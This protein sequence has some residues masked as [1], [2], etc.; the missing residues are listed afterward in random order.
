L[1]AAFISAPNINPNAC[2]E[3]VSFAEVNNII[4]VRCVSCHSASPTDDIFTKAP[5][6]VMYD[7]PEQITSKKDLIMQRVVHTKT[8][9]QN[10]KT[11]ITEEERNLIRCWIE[12]GAKLK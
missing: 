2:N 11:N 8:M 12:Q 5:N 6:G 1:S 3:N 10:N 4:Q 9:P 7:T